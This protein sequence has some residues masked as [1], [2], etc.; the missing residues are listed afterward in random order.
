MND[1]INISSGAKWEDL[2]GYSRAVKIG[3][4]IEVS[5]TTAVEN[6]EIVGKGDEYLQAKFIF[7]KI[8][9]ALKQLGSSLKDVIK[10]KIYVTNISKWEEIGRA[11]FE[12][13]GEIRPVTT[14]VEVSSLINSELLV[15][16]EVS[17]VIS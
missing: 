15:E 5:G 11:H 3:K 14:M 1:R 4:I 13:F 12:F 10:T 8:E 2:V 6:G 17:A 7:Q 9:T 16:I